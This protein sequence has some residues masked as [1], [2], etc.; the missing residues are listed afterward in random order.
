M[1]K[2]D[3]KLLLNIEFLTRFSLFLQGS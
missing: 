2:V 1:D 3:S